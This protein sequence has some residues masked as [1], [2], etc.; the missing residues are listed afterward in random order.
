MKIK[1]K[2]FD[3]LERIIQRVF[4]IDRW[5]R[6]GKPGEMINLLPPEEREELTKL[7]SKEVEKQVTP[8]APYWCDN[9]YR[10]QDANKELSEEKKKFDVKMKFWMM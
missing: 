9:Y 1:L 6:P 4:F 3:V 10:Q 5:R 2:A 8:P 7:T